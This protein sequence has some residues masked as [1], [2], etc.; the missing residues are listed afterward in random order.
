MLLGMMLDRA[1][2]E[3]VAIYLERRLW[4]P[5]GA[6]FAA[7]WSLDSA[8]SGFE[9]MESGINARQI[10]FLMIGELVRRG[11]IAETGERLLPAEWIEQITAPTAHATGWPFGPDI[12]YG[13]LWWGFVRADGPPDVFADG[14]FGQV[15]LVSRVNDVVLLRTG[16]GEGGVASWPRLLC[17]LAVALGGPVG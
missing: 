11:G 3:H 14:I 7:S 12:F 16:D 5:M 1:L 17:A 6:E 8:A 4:Q 2:H 10:D 13:L 15:L 9:K